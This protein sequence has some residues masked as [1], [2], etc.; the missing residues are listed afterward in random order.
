MKKIIFWIIIA[1]SS[2][3]IC[4]CDPA[5]VAI[6]EFINNSSLNL[7]IELVVFGFRNGNEIFNVMKNTSTVYKYS[8]IDRYDD[9]NDFIER[10]KFH[11]FDSQEFIYEMIVDSETF[12]FIKE[13]KNG[14]GMDGYFKLEIDDNS[15]K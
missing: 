11:D 13:K 3:S 5:G 12:T 1:V 9:P 10:M 8:S 4:T 2:V 6:I 14:L 7:Q 15:F